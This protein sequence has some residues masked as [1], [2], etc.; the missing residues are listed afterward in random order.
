MVD[1]YAGQGGT[2]LIDPETG[3]RTLIEQTSPSENPELV[4]EDLTN[5]TP[6]KENNS[7]RKGGE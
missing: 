6:S 2:F 7:T 4:K 5:G 1:K 3:E